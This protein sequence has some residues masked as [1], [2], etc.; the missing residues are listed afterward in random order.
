MKQTFGLGKIKLWQKLAAVVVLLSVP[1]AVLLYLNVRDKQVSIEFARVEAD[2][3]RYLRALRE[4]TEQVAQ[5]SGPSDN[6]AVNQVE[7]SLR[8]LEELDRQLGAP[9]KTTD[10]LRALTDQWRV[11][12]S[13]DAAEP[14][15][16]TFLAGLRDLIMQA[17]DVSGLFVDP[18]LDAV[19]VMETVALE[20]PRQQDTLAQAVALGRRALLRKELPLADKVKLLRLTA[21][22]QAALDTAKNNIE[23]ASGYNAGGTVQ[24]LAARVKENTAATQAFLEL[25]N[26]QVLTPAKPEADPKLLSEAGAQALSTSFKFW[27]DASTTLDNLIRVRRDN[28]TWDK[29]TF[30]AVGFVMVLITGFVLL[31]I[32]H[33]FTQQLK[34]LTTLVDQI[35]AGNKAARAAVLGEDE[36]GTLAQAF[37]KMLDDNQGLLQTSAERDEIQRSIMKLLDEVSGVAA[38]DLSRQAEVTEGL[39]GAI[40][41]AFNYMMAQLREII[42]KVQSVAR[43]VNVSANTTQQNTQQLAE[44]ANVRAEQLNHAAREV[45]AMAFSIRNVAE[46]AEASKAVAQKTLETAQRGS[47]ILQNTIQGVTQVREQVSESAA[48]LR[49]VNEHSREIGE[50]VKIIE[51]IAKRTGVLALHAS[52]QAASAGEAGRGFAV[53]VREV[54]HLAERSTEAAKLI[55]ELVGRA[56]FG[57]Q[58]AMTAMEESTR[59]VN[60][61]T[62]LICEAGDALGEIEQ[63]LGQLAELIQSISHTT[64]VQTKDSAAVS[65]TMVQLSE[66]T[67]QTATGIARSAL[68]VTQL[69]ALADDLN[70]SVASFKLAAHHPPAKNGRT[71]RLSPARFVPTSSHHTRDLSAEEW[72]SGDYSGKF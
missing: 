66:A 25:L 49:L 28:L 31:V 17:T 64:D 22:T 52:I 43:E 59:G 11:V 4:L 57:A 13:K 19:Y 63:V 68:T 2:G 26:Q 62:S 8:K 60:E 41:D 14:E 67:R 53:V 55:G 21:E 9:L 38:G 20:L 65:H 30:V 12:K 16:A 1:I 42:G 50:V 45:D 10:K 71:T 61:G 58:S 56:R 46:T 51:E 72:V 35:G 7:S 39:T 36:L 18:D 24:P 34:A 48:R 15:Y 69:A 27:D 3:V 54:E 40:A 44:E 5:F 23:K 33:G 29:N 32:G 47:R 6:E 37:N 70:G